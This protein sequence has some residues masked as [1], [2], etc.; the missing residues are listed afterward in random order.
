MGSWRK[1]GLRE[2]VVPA[3]Y[4][5][6]WFVCAQIA[7]GLTQGADGIAAVWPSSGIFVAALL[8]L[9]H[10]GRIL[11]TVGIGIASFFANFGSGVGL[12]ASIGFTA[13]NLIEGWL[14]FF[15]MGGAGS[16][17][18]ALRD[19]V[20]L[21]RFAGAALLAGAI[22][23]VMAGLLSLN[24]DPVFL[25]S[26]ASTVT[27]GMLIVTPVILFIAQDQ[28]AMRHL[29]SLRTLWVL[30]IVGLLT[31][32]AFA[33]SDYPLLFLPMVAIS[34]ATA[35]LGLSGTS[36]AIL[37]VVAIGSILTVSDIGPISVFVSD[38]ED[39]VVFFQLYVLSLLVS[40]MPVALVLALRKRDLLVSETNKRLLEAAERAAK[41][42]HW[43]YDVL[44]ETFH[45]SKEARRMIGMRDLP[46]SIDATVALL[47][48]KDRVRVHGLI[49]QAQQHGIPFVFEAQV[50]GNDPAP[51]HVE[52]RGEVE[53]AP[54]GS[55]TSLFG[56]IMDVSERAETMRQLRLAQL[57]AEKEAA[58]VRHLA[59]TDYLTGIANRRRI[60][61][62][63]A[64][65]VFHAA[66]REELLAVALFD[67]DH[68]KTIND[69][70]GHDA[71]DKTLKL[72]CRMIG[73][74][75]GP[76]RKLGRLG[77][78]EFLALAPGATAQELAETCE[79]IGRHLAN[80]P[81]PFGQGER[82]TMSVGVAELRPGL[83]DSSLL[84]AADI[85]LYHAKGSGR[86][87]T[88]IYGEDIDESID[89]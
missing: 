9:A 73:E 33:Q 24:P 48:E 37:V 58:E 41:M 52:C 71:G 27:L 86:A 11:A 16:A 19:P 66:S 38:V 64:D 74:R 80:L 20:N 46:D 17:A 85:A 49:A 36:L 89:A 61:G 78:E 51:M 21:L 32:T 10:R 63:L 29:L 14:V 45:W 15:L 68:F 53:M 1:P 79:D 12:F 5:L 34:V 87:Q 65:M 75:L 40:A 59:E 42:G 35:V 39:R 69:R 57:R 72:F 70:F 43:R 8:H 76:G 2:F 54:D 26:W 83:N 30:L 3:L 4:S 50:A 62:D 81:L 55:A 60:L 31:A 13:A 6:A 18:R 67:I 56:T 44:A 28:Q 82:V 84:K 7:L 77:G 88:V 25:W 47:H 23:A 22:S